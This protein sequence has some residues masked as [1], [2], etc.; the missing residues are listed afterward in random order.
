M[1][2]LYLYIDDYH[3]FK[4]AEFNFSQ[5]V[6]LRYDT[7]EK[8]V[9]AVD[10]PSC[11]PEGFW[12]GNIRNLSMI[13]GNNG[14]G[15]TSLMQYL[16]LMFQN[17]WSGSI[18]V[19]GR[20]ILVL[21]EED[22]LLYYVS[23]EWKDENI[24]LTTSGR[25]YRR[26]I[27]LRGGRDVLELAGTKLIYLTNAISQ[28]DYQRSKMSGSQRF[29]PLYD[30]SVGSI[31]FQDSN[32][33][34][35]RAIRRFSYLNAGN[36]KIRAS[37][38]DFSEMETYFIYEQY[39]QIK[40][41]FDKN[42]YQ[43][44]TKLREQ[45]Y[46]VP[47]PKKLHMEM[48]L[49]DGLWLVLDEE[50]CGKWNG[51]RQLE[52][53]LFAGINHQWEEKFAKYAKVSEDAENMSECG[54]VEPYAYEFL[55]YELGRC[56][57]WSAIRSILRC[58]EVEEEFIYNSVWIHIS[59]CGGEETFEKLM[60]KLWSE[61]DGMKNLFGKILEEN[62]DWKVLMSLKDYYLEYMKFIENEKL[63]EHFSI[64]TRLSGDFKQDVMRGTFQFSIRTEDADWFMTFLQKYRYICNP[65][66]FLDFNW[67]LSSGENNLLSMFASLYYIFDADYT[68]RKN[69]EYKILN[70]LPLKWGQVN[71]AKCDSVIL[72]IDEADLTYHPEWQRE[73]IS[74]LTAFL[75]H[76]YTPEC[77]QNIQVILS[78]HSP[79]LLGDMPQQ[80]VIYLKFDDRNGFTKVDES[81]HTGTFGQNIHLLFRDSFF[82]EHGTMGQFAQDKI[83]GL[84]KMLI[85]IE[86]ELE[87]T[88]KLS[89][90]WKTLQRKYLPML[91]GE[92]RQIA[93][94][95]AE[96]I[97]RRKLL[98]KIDALVV[99][100][101]QEKE[102]GLKALS[103][104]AIEQEIE[105][106]REEQLRRKS[107]RKE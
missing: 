32:N 33:D 71:Y 99:E 3:N 48:M 58:P 20:G 101:V 2:L 60:D 30:A 65:D 63:E 79:L 34:V 54:M 16:I 106:L 39:K 31:V 80:N 97:I 22:R 17:L 70:N 61:V 55:R 62:R 9:S 38:L 25:K 91:Q 88:D 14:A 59:D 7:E 23:G 86:E 28:A 69:G 40:F 90:K 36:K 8:R 75:P 103:D 89:E 29:S 74:L 68:D 27:R 87:K 100:L 42:Q 105:R 66:Y 26:V 13:V 19:P 6:R 46:P 92:C 50:T 18:S 10:V 102:D 11:V 49:E 1:E 85:E 4:E 15:K 45:G 47:L 5:K 98:M 78:T 64:E 51:K 12:G 107:S 93:D 37:R 52:D 53:A 84:L 76:L 96:P 81:V 57:V 43:T 72:M 35:N 94:L 104:E 56:A 83:N 77:C 44:L 82:L 41:M 67:G 73:Y 21:G 95:I 24:S